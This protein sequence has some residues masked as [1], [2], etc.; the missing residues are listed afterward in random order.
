M[1]VR[2]RVVILILLPVT[3]LLWLIGWT[4]FWTGSETNPH[5][6]KPIPQ[7]ETAIT[8]HTT[9]RLRRNQNLAQ[10]S[11]QKKRAHQQISA[12]KTHQKPACN[13]DRPKR[14]PK[15]A[16][17]DPMQ[18]PA[19]SP[20]G[21]MKL[22]QRTVTKQHYNEHHNRD[23]RVSSESSGDSVFKSFLITQHYKRLAIQTESGAQKKSSQKHITTNN[24]KKP[25][26]S[27]AKHH[28]A[29]FQHRLT[30]NNPPGLA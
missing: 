27:A 9:R 10:F 5:K 17:K 26:T 8:H 29:C 6:V 3:T 21:K 19:A 25:D 16:P 23:S 14:A 11:C 2:N 24:T 30:Q 18:L 20:C 1:R 13:P 28:L 4:L 22:Q 7:T 12:L 15:H